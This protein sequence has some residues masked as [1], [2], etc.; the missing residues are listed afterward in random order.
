MET[1]TRP[2]GDLFSGRWIVPVT[3]FRS[4]GVSMIEVTKALS[5]IISYPEFLAC[6]MGAVKRI[7]SS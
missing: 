3:E 1:V 4:T 5:F 7:I 6:G 2:T